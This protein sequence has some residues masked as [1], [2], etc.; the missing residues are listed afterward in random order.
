MTIALCNIPLIHVLM[1]GVIQTVCSRLR[2]AL[3]SH[4]LT[5]I[6]V[7]KTGFNKYVSGDT[8]AHV[9]C[10]SSV[11]TSLVANNERR[12]P[13]A[14]YRWTGWVWDITG[15]DFRRLQKNDRSFQRYLGSIPPII[16]A[17]PKDVNLPPV[18][19][20]NIRISTDSAQNPA[21]TLVVQAEGNPLG[22]E[23]LVAHTLSLRTV[24]E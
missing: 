9:V 2:N 22:S 17:K 16:K 7:T 12:A 10:T 21:Q 20:G 4:T 3:R 19:L 15:W 18:G 8:Y 11:C 6:L 1:N 24:C 5:E 23:A 14:S 13:T